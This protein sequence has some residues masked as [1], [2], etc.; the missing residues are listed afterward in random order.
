MMPPVLI[1]SDFSYTKMILRSPEFGVWQ[2]SE[3][4]ENLVKAGKA[5]LRICS[6]EARKICWE[7]DSKN[8]TDSDIYPAA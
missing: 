6:A 2:K 7:I 4:T 8:V 3:V 1:V 5:N